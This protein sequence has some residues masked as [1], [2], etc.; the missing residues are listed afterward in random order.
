MDCR[1]AE[2]VARGGGYYVGSAPLFAS[3]RVRLGA[4]PTAG[5]DGGILGPGAVSFK[6]VDTVGCYVDG[7]REAVTNAECQ[8]GSG[9]CRGDDHYVHPGHG[10]QNAAG[11]RARDPT[12]WEA[13]DYD[14]EPVNDGDT[15]Y[16]YDY[17]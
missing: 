5:R 8:P 1:D 2:S 17:D 11:S 15:W 4:A 14:D 3:Q 16:D 13:F 7:G 9:G 10:V 12:H 6:R